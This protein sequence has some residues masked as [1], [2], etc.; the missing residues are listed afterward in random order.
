MTTK[1]FRV[2]R[3][4]TIAGDTTGTTSLAAA[5]SGGDQNYTLPTA[6]PT[7]NGYVLASQTDG[8]MSWAD[9]T[10]TTYT[11][12]AST[13]LGGANLNLNGSDSTV[14]S[15][16]FTGTTGVTVT[17][18]D[19]NTIDIAIGQPVAPTDTV[20]FNSL[21]V[22][23]GYFT[24]DPGVAVTMNQQNIQIGDST[25]ASQGF[26]IS[27][28][29]GHGA[30]LYFDPTTDS[31]YF[32][33]Q[34]AGN[35]LTLSPTTAT[36]IGDLDVKGGDITNS[37]GALQLTTASNG[38]IT[39]AP[40]GTGRITLGSDIVNIGDG[41]ATSELRAYTNTT[42]RLSAVETTSGA[43]SYID[44]ENGANANIKIAPNGTGDVHIYTDSTRFGD[45][46]AAATLTTY[47]TGDLI[48]RTNEGSAVEGSITLANGA[49]GNM[50]LAPN[51]SGSVALTLAN[52]GNLTNTR[53]YVLG[54]IRDTTTAAAG[55][56]WSY[57]LGGAL[58][59]R[60]VSLDNT[61]DTTKRPGMVL[62]SYGSTNNRPFILGE[63]N[64]GTV[65]SPL[66]TN[67][68]NTLL[69]IDGSGYN[70]TQWATDAVSVAPIGITFQAAENWTT[71][72]NGSRFRVDAQ[73]IGVSPSG[74]TRSN[75]I[76][77]TSSQAT[78]RSDNWAFATREAG[79]QGGAGQ[80]L[81]TLAVVGSGSSAE[82]TL[83]LLKTDAT[84]ANNQGVI[85]FT[86]QRSTGGTYSPTQSGDRLGQ[87]KFNGNTS[88]TTTPAVGASP[89]LAIGAVA[90]E[91]WTVSAQGT[92]LLIQAVKNGATTQTDI[93]DH[94]PTA[95]VYKS[96][97]FTF[98]T[99]TGSTILAFDSS[100]NLTIGG[101]LRINGNDIKASD[102]NTAI[103]M[104]PITS[105][106]PNTDFSG[107][108]VKG[109]LRAGTG[110]ANG[111]I[112][113][114]LSGATPSTGI[115]V[116]N[117]DKVADRTSVVIRNYG[118]SLTGGLPR[119]NVIMEAARGTAASPT[120]VGNAD[121]LMEIQANGY[122]STG[123]ATDLSATIPGLIR[124]R[125]AEA[126]NN[127][128]NNTGTTFQVVTNPTA[129][130]LS[131]TSLIATLINNPQS[132]LIRSDSISFANKAG[133]NTFNVSSTGQISGYDGAGTNTLFVDSNGDMTLN[134]STP[135]TTGAEFQIPAG[136]VPTGGGGAFLQV[137]DV[138]IAQMASSWQSV[139][140][141]GFKYTGLASSST[142]TGN[143]TL[144][145]I[146]SRWKANAGTSTYDPPQTDWGIGAFQFSADNSTTATSQKPA[147]QIRVVATENWDATHWGTK[148]T[149]DANVQGTGGGK[150]V[151]SLSP[152]TS[153]ISTDALAF[154]DSS[155]SPLVGD[156]ITYNRVYG[157]WYQG[158]ITPVATTATPLPI[159]SATY[160]NIATVG[161][162]T[163][164][165]PGATGKYILNYGFNAGQPGG[166]ALSNI[167]VSLYKNGTQVTDTIRNYVL[168]YDLNAEKIF[169]TG[170]WMIDPLNTTDYYEI[171]YDWSIGSITAETLSALT[172]ILT[173]VGI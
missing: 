140:S 58:G 112:F 46:N 41:A 60:G 6:L 99:S 35:L 29:I 25:S 51:G 141:P 72:A 147:G 127:G 130:T 92:K 134:S 116:D 34:A 39:L 45:Q 23:G 89:A 169:I 4:L 119:A 97:S 44:I 56:I 146:S 120:N 135:S 49:N 57:L 96:D 42:L 33:S 48:L 66:T 161:S 26:S 138:N 154:N 165:I 150:Q 19:A 27:G 11:I 18:P 65:A 86:T 94:S 98:A 1:N 61:G 104:V 54:T 8:T 28:S 95:A 105:N 144:F 173:P 2:R 78:Y 101:D 7:T 63:F 113:E 88:S 13:T 107:N 91:N 122:T 10:N 14:D 108:I 12:D 155:G 125:A 171:Y 102:G 15:V 20:S 67:S 38:A 55:D 137:G 153:S 84:G 110:E 170:Q 70:G 139:Y 87:Y 117:T 79:P 106:N 131:A 121:N 136:T 143:G 100:G 103:T 166:N 152:E 160:S 68:G 128:L 162:T 167:E 114:F 145:E 90:T 133:N 69:E 5:N 76:N 109:S 123:W 43:T 53:N 17:A 62:R 80:T 75:L 132:S 172:T 31:F 93:I 156:K 30:F 124:I 164:I 3:G 16:T 77:H 24:T 111:N 115:S 74:L 163:R 151:A 142:L 159:G 149:L 64:R 158:G 9:N 83:N 32:D 21:T 36:L 85:N 40:N 71:T 47:G 73:P 50:T 81:V 37:T 22:T 52:G 157:S 126:W 148:I 168:P 82:N 59:V 118:G 129:T